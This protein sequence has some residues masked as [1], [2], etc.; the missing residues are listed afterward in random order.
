M[1]TLRDL[2]IEFIDQ[3]DDAKAWGSDPDEFE[4]VD[5]DCHPMST[6]FRDFLIRNHRD[7]RLVELECSSPIDTMVGPYHAVVETDGLC[8]DWTA[9]QFYNVLNFRLAY[10]EIPCPLIFV[11]GGPYPLPDI[12]ISEEA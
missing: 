10:D 7:A 2:I 3:D 9:R 4:S 8:V 5:A 11:A 1:K 6:R 12:I